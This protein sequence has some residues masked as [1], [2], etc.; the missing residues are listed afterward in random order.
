MYTS[1]ARRVFFSAAVAVAVAV[2][3]REALAQDRAPAAPGKGAA[4]KQYPPVPRMAGGKPDL[5]GVWQAGS[6]RIGTWEEVNGIA[7]FGGTGGVPTPNPIQP[8]REPPPYQPGAAAK[9]LESYNRRA[10][11][12][13]M[14]RCLPP[15]VPRVTS[16]GA[17]FPMQ[18]VHQP[19]LVVML[20]EVFHVFRV[21][22]IDA[23]H[24]EDVEPSYMGDSVGRWEGDT[25]VVDVTGFNDETWLAGVGS[26]HSEDLHV[27]ER[28]TR[29]DYN[30]IHYQATMVDPKVF[31]KP[32]TTRNT[33]MLRP[34]TRLREYECQ[35][36]NV[37]SERYEKLLKD[38]S[39][40][41]R[42]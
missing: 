17:L 12:D 9:A 10:I 31:T 42:R 40:F 23:S 18:I 22:P 39:V 25:L 2:A 16:L 35:Q 38:E 8:L 26:F 19:K 30:T 1:G 37:D 7:G 32:W 36:N 27:T 15:G 20:Y 4:A 5:N 29:V 21:I 11:D 33:I 3:S 41:R 28:Y 14:A 6:N 24:P 34:G 13:P